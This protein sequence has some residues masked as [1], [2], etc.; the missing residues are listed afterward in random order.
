MVPVDWKKKVL[1]RLSRVFSRIYRAEDGAEHDVS[2]SRVVC[3]WKRAPS[4]LP[5]RENS[6]SL[7]LFSNV[8]I[9]KEEINAESKKQRL[10]QKRH[11]APLVPQSPC[12][13]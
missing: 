7:T 10:N 12:A 8:A 11:L 4:L 5:S 2:V 13:I 6:L 1:R 9:V 3:G